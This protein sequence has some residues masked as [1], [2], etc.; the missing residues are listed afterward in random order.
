[1]KILRYIF[2][3]PIAYILSLIFNL[4]SIFII[5]YINQFFIE[6]DGFWISLFNH[7]LFIFKFLNKYFLFTE[8]FP[9][10][11]AGKLFITTGLLIFPE[12]QNS[13][14]MSYKI[15][16]FLLLSFSL[17]VLILNL[18][19]QIKD[20]VSILNCTFY[21]LGSVVASYIF[22]RKTDIVS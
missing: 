9:S 8:I 5:E 15:P 10:Y 2:F 3:I 6:H 16:I 20:L 11:Y 7:K 12:S 13:N 17:I 19:F 1:M 22:I 18:I 4:I 14:K 21:F